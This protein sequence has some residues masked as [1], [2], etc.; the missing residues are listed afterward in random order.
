MVLHQKT[1]ENKN[2]NLIAFRIPIELAA[3]LEKS[4]VNPKEACRRFLYQIA[5][6]NSISTAKF[7]EKPNLSL[8]SEIGWCGG[9]DLNPRRPTP[10][11]LKSSPLS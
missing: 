1:E 2:R 9:W 3:T 7:P 11:D 4:S 6:Q 5:T 10:E 8:A